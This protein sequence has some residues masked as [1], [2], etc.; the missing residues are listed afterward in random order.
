MIP[1]EEHSHQA[2]RPLPRAIFSVCSSRF[3]A[4]DSIREAWTDGTT[5]EQVD[6]IVQRYRAGYFDA[7]TD[8]YEYRDDRGFGL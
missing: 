7:I 2:R 1:F 8:C 5:V 4:G 3:S 6:A